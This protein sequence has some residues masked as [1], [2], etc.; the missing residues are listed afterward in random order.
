MNT[1]I[2][3]GHIKCIPFYYNVALE[4]NVTKMKTECI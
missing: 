4:L 2:Q 1:D 3:S